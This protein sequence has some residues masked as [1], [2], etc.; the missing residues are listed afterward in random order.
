[1]IFI[2]KKINEYY[3]LL[4][5]EFYELLYYEFYELLYYEFY[6]FYEFYELLTPSKILITFVFTSSKD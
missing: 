6:E 4:Y 5:Y 2:I 1:M 3:E